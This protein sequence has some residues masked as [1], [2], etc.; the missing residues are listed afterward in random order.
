MYH[1]R[2]FPIDEITTEVNRVDRATIQ[3]L[4]NELL[5]SDRMALTLLG[6]LGDLKI[7]R[8]DLAC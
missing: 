2:F 7:E 3:R 8:A 6:N 1:G 4:A 5:Q